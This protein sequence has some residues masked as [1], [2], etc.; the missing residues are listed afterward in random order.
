M[1]EQNKLERQQSSVYYY[2]SISDS[3]PCD[4]YFKWSLF[5]ILC[6][7]CCLPFGIPAMVYARLTRK[8]Q[9]AGDMRAAEQYKRRAYLFNLLASMMG[10]SV[11]VG[12]LCWSLFG[13]WF[14]TIRMPI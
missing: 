10:V 14:Y 12:I 1:D 4:D 3:G 7:C 11:L 8:L 9:R 5:N 6:C 13:I 2:Q